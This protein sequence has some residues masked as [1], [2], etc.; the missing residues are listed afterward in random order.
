MEAEEWTESVKNENDHLGG[1]DA[2]DLF[3]SEG[4]LGSVA[5]EGM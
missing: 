2:S 3:L 5:V 1:V 4:A